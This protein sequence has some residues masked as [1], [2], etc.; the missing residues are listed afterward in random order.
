MTNRRKIIPIAIISLLGLAVAGW[1]LGLFSAKNDG[2]L[3][4][5][6][7]VDIREVDMAFRI[8]GRIAT[9]PV[10]EGDTV[11]PGQVI[12]TLE[13][14]PVQDRVAA[15]SA[16]V[17]QAQA[18]LAK[19]ENGNRPQD[20]AQA[21]AR[22]EAAKVARDYAVKDYNR[23]EPLVASGTISRA[24]W[25]QTVANRREA[26]A[27]LVEA[28]KALELLEAGT[29]PEDLAAARAQLANAQAQQQS[30]RT[31]LGDT[32]LV[33]PA[34]GT[35]L[36]RA[37]EPGA[38]AQP[39]QAVM[40]IAMNRPMRVRAYVGEPDLG[41]VSPGMKVTLKT[42]GSERT[43]HGTI[44]FISARAEFTPKSVETE[45][46][47]T[48]LV[49]RLRIVVSDPDDRLRQGQPVTVIVPDAG[50]AGN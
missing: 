6:G 7:N 17:G 4:L 21:R 26:E 47:R 2:Q 34:D 15:A 32:K 1:A 20:I 40:I 42:D 25:D 9:I 45:D 18:T 23:R 38:I 37:M 44:G 39:G 41:R 24:A 43:Y 11:K 30:A 36:T 13:T 22:A 16:A 35:I 8:S 5:Y 3:T 46:L 14:A 50:P 29:R 48:D 49:Y 10:E 33:A 31:D 19:A 27:R 12:A 28:S